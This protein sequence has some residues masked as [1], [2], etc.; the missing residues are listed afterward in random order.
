MKYLIFGGSFNP[1]HVGHLQIAKFIK[2]K[3][4]FDE[5][6]FMPVYKHPWNKELIHWKHRVRMLELS[7]NDTNKSSFVPPCSDMWI[8]KHEITNKII[9]HTYKSLQLFFRNNPKIA[10][11]RPYLLI[12]ADQA[13]L[14]QEW[15]DWQ[16]LMDF[17][18]FVIMNRQIIIS[19]GEFKQIEKEE[20]MD[21]WI[22]NPPHM[23]IIEKPKYE[24]DHISSTNIRK[25]LREGKNG[26]WGPLTISVA[27]YIRKHKLYLK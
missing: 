10:K 20:V 27:T 24:V 3:Y 13:N 11:G 22:N 15:K 6:I 4:K 14:I 26:W 7:I 17:I 1:P 5:V 25:R 21:L 16:K 23:I 12:G 19:H 9:G 8:S 18:P 2:D